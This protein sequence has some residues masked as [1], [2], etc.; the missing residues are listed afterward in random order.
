[1]PTVTASWEWDIYWTTHDLLQKG[2]PEAC[3]SRVEVLADNYL[4]SQRVA[5]WMVIARGYYVSRAEFV[6]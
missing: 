3:R 1:M 2:I 5:L 4:E 6:M